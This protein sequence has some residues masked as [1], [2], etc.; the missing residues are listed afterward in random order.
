MVESS[1]RLPIGSWFKIA[2]VPD[3]PK[4]VSSPPSVHPAG[5]GYPSQGRTRSGNPTSIAASSV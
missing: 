1:E 5:N 4:K 3:F 2:C